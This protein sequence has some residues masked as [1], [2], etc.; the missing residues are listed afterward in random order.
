MLLNLRTA[1]HLDR[2]RGTPRGVG[3]RGGRHL[4]TLAAGEREKATRGQRSGTHQGIISAASET[5]AAH[6]CH[7]ESNL[8]LIHQTSS[9]S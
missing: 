5:A 4:S 7:R 8:V 1:R 9:A 3:E 2:Q 6:A